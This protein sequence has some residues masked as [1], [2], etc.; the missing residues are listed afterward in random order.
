MTKGKPK[1]KL[2]YVTLGKWVDDANLKAVINSGISELESTNL[3]SE[4]TCEPI[5]TSAIHKLYTKT[6]E[7][8]SATIT[9][10][11]KVTLPDIRDVKESYYGML[12]FSEFRKLLVDD[13]DKI[14][15]IFYDN[16]RDYLG[17]NSVNEKIEKTL[18]EGKY[19]IFSILNNGVTIVASELNSAGNRYTLTD[20][21]IVN[22]CQTSHVLYSFRDAEDISDLSIPIKLIITNNDDVKNQITVATNSQTEVKPEQLEALSDFQKSLEYYYNSINGDGVLYYER[23]TNQYNSNND[24]PKTRIVSIPN[25]IKSFSSMF[26]NNPHLVSGYYGTIARDLGEQIFKKDHKYIPYYTSSY[27][28]YRLESLFRSGNIDSKYKKV[29]YQLIM[30]LRIL[31]SGNQMPEFNS[32]KMKAYCEKIIDILD[33]QDDSLTYFNKAIEVIIDANLDLENIRQFKDSQTTG[34]LLETVKKKNTMPN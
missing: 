28:F 16:V 12:P 8:S 9:F 15:P 25:Q 14:R 2:S 33:N 32:K 5:D 18:S 22:G 6:K 34:D 7:L 1:L 31:V 19:D 30:L 10:K 24:I 27:A 3:F 4:V 26:L 20:Y 17:D 29:K 23:R 11:D 13:N 21:Q